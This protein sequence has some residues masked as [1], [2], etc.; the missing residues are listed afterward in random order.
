MHGMLALLLTLLLAACK[1][2]I[3]PPPKAPI[4]SPSPAPP[5]A[6]TAAQHPS[7]QPDLYLA[8]PAVL[9]RLN[10]ARAALGAPPLQIDRG[11]ALVAQQASAHYQRLGAGLDRRTAE[12]LGIGDKVADEAARELAAFSLTFSDV[13]AAVVCVEELAQAVDALRP[14]LALDPAMRYAGLVVTRSP[15]PDT[16]YAVVLMLGQ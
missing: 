10:A 13:R 5:L 14:A 6:P 4:P 16:G 3:Q 7:A 11:L 15:G 8:M 12:R 1:Q 9:N 2:G